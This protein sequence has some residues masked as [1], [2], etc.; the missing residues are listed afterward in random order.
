M[1]PWWLVCVAKSLR[2]AIKHQASR[3]HP[4]HARPIRRVAFERSPYMLDTRAPSKHPSERLINI[5]KMIMNSTI[6]CLL[7]RTSYLLGA[8]KNYGVPERH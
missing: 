1:P 2:S 8:R 3:M 4:R 5:G 7:C 6:I